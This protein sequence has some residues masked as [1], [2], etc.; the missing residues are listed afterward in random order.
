M[1]LADRRPRLHAE[2]LDQAG[3]QV[4]VDGEG[5]GLA[6]GAVEGEH[7]LA[8]VGLAQGV[9]GGERGEFGDEGARPGVGEGELG[10]VVPLQ[11]E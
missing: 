5:L 9:F 8:V 6:A 7:Q 4:A 2:F 11:E 1:C 10:I 3:A